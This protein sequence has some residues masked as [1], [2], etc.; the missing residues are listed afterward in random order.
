M[1]KNKRPY[2]FITN[3]DGVNSK[4]IKTLIKL[5]CQLGDVVVVAPDGARSGMSN[6]LTVN[7]PIK[8][9]TIENKENLTIH[10]CTGTP[11]DCVKLA[12]DEILTKTPDL[13]VSGINHGSNASINVIYSG[14]MGATLE[15]CEKGI[16]SIGFSLCDHSADADFS[17][18]EPYILKI[19][20][21]VIEQGI[22]NSVCLN[23]NA[24][25]G[26]LK[27]VQIVRQ[28]KGRWVNEFNKQQDADGKTE[29]QLVGEYQNLEP[30]AIDTDEWVLSQ[31]Y[32]SIVPTK[33]DLTDYAIIK[34]LNK[35]SW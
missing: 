6:A 5:M 34:D 1:K 13:L 33:T 29:Y 24:P 20:Q 2:I 4:G 28:C 22:P 11:T 15:G 10:S 27:G 35:W 26:K 14:T 23:V 21:K 3:D 18:F 30:N 12:F 19:A 25:V 16:P 31:G 9:K 32:V 7:H 17:Y 8:Y